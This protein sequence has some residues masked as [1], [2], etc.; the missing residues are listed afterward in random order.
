[1]SKMNIVW[2]DL[3]FCM[4]RLYL[5]YEYNTCASVIDCLKNITSAS[6]PFPWLSPDGP[7]VDSPL[8]CGRRKTLVIGTSLFG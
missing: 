8:C 7:G 4:S 1:M 5:Y 3:F 6:S 2:H